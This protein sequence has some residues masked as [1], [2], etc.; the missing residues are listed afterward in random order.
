MPFSSSKCQW[1]SIFLAHCAITGC[2]H[3]HTYGEDFAFHNNQV[4]KSQWWWWWFHQH[5]R[6]K[7]VK[8]KENCSPSSLSVF[9]FFVLINSYLFVHEWINDDYR[10][11]NTSQGR[12]HRHYHFVY[13][14]SLYV[15]VSF[16]TRRKRKWRLIREAKKI[17]KCYEP[18]RCHLRIRQEKIH[19]NF[20]TWM[21]I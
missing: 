7:K 3:M 8:E 10:L 5:Q 16:I 18:K 19:C 14:I 17:N 9:L 1:S 20:V 2:V 4:N 11:I 15:C 12:N 13:I 21:M 6:R